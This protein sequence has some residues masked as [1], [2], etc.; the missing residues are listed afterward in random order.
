MLTEF[1]FPN[2]TIVENFNV[3]DVITVFYLRDETLEEL[4]ITGVVV[5][6][7]NKNKKTY[8]K[9]FVNDEIILNFCLQ[10]PFVVKVILIKLSTEIK[11]KI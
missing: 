7:K 11:Y 1:K 5:N 6:K 10:S 2:G 3:G 8:C 4:R 9:V